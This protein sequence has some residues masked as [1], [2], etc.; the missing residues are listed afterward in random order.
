MQSPVKPASRSTGTPSE[1]AIERKTAAQ[2]L[3][4]ADALRADKR[5]LSYA[6]IDSNAG[7]WRYSAKSVKT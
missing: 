7:K 5:R 6:S 1:Y 2:R 3:E 4:T